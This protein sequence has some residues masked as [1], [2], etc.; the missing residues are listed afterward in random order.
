[1]ADYTPHIEL[2]SKAR[3]DAAFDD[4]VS[5]ELSDYEYGEHAPN[6]RAKRAP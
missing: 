1:M 2:L 6:V 5:E 3:A 4:F